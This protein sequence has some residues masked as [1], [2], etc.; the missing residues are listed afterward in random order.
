MDESRLQE[1]VN[2]I[3]ALLNC[4][5]G[6]EAQ[7]LSANQQLVDPGLVQT[8]LRVANEQMTLGKLDAANF[9]MNLARQLMGALGASGNTPLPTSPISTSSSI[10]QSESQ[11]H[12]LLRVLQA[13]DESK[14][15]P[16]VVYPLLQGNLDLLDD[17]FAQVLKNWATG[18]LSVVEPDTAYAFAATIFDFSNLIKEFPLGK[19]A[20][21]LEIAIALTQ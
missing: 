1:Y 5:S 18:T 2:L 20:I 14:G 11:R 3:H 19:Q 6:E 7:V 17:N 15:N 10:P 8:M 13:T 9:L 4:P 21:N 12:F 16:Q